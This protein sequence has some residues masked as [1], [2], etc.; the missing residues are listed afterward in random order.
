MHIKDNFVLYIHIYKY[1]EA[2][3]ST[4]MTKKD[5]TWITSVDL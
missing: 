1:L 3:K 4:R 5:F 2:R